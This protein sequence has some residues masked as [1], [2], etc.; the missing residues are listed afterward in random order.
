LA[1]FRLATLL[2]AVAG[3]LDAA[4]FFSANITGNVSLLSD[5]IAIGEWFGAISYLLDVLAF[6]FGAGFCT[7]ILRAC[8]WPNVEGSHAYLV[9]LKAALIL[10]LAWFGT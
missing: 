5:R 8:E 1:D 9:V 6:I 3:A 2:A 10:P 7:L 4:A